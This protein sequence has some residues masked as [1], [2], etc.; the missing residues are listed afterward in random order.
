MAADQSASCS[1]NLALLST[2]HSVRRLTLEDVDA[3]YELCRFNTLF[4]QYHPPFVTRESILEDMLALPPSKTMA[5]KYYLGFYKER[6]LVAVMDLI[7]GYPDE[8]TVWIGFFMTAVQ[9]QRKGVGSSLIQQLSVQLKKEGFQRIR[10]GVDHGNP[11]SLAFWQKNGF[12][13]IRNDHFLV[14]ERML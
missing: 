13:V 1:I 8:Q 9:Q 12:S 6:V 14:M 11:Q 7:A 4:Y 5:D 2:I 3:I 10:L